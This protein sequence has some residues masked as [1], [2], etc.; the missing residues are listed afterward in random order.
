MDANELLRQYGAGERIFSGSNLSWSNLSG[1]NLSGS[2]LRGSNLRGSDLSESDLSE[3]N[4]R[5][6]DLSGSNLRGSDLSES[7]LRGSDLSWSNLS[8]SNLRWSDLSGSNL[9]GSNLRGSNLPSPGMILLA[10]WGEVSDSL[11][12]ELMRYDAANHPDPSSFDRWAETGSCPYEDCPVQRSVNFTQRRNLW[13][14]GP[15]RP[16]YELMVQLIR[17]KCADSDYHHAEGEDKS[18]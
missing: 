13:S 14:P 7:D 1:S 4:L 11:C 16:A 12:I 17:E 5:W 9:R 8:G 15:G 2:N 6:S 10:Q 3:S 18:D